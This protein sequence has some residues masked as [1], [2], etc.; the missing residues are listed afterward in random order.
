M[1]KGGNEILATKCKAADNMR[2]EARQAQAGFFQHALRY[3]F[4][5]YA[6]DTKLVDPA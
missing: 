2:F 6:E 3:S 4:K 5:P 1:E